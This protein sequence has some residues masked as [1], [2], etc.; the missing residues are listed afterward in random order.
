MIALILQMVCVFATS[1][2]YVQ[3]HKEDNSTDLLQYFLLEEKH[4]CKRIC[5][6]DTI[7]MLCHYNFVVEWYQTLSKACYDCP[8]TADDCNR[9]HCIVGDGRKRPILVVNRQMPGPSIEVNM[10]KCNYYK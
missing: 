4:P 2:N 8:Y 3:S 5:G 10:L 1:M 9:P 7:P 6:K